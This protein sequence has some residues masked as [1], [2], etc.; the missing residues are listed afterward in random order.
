[1]SSGILEAVYVEERGR[2]LAT[3]IRMARNFEDA[4][5]ALQDAVTKWPRDS[6]PQNPGAWL[7]TVAKNSLIDRRR[8]DARRRELRAL[9]V[10]TQADEELP[11][12]VLRLIFLCCHPVLSPEAQIAL[13]LRT[14]GGLE[15][16]EIARA[17]L[18]P[19]PT[20][21]Q[22]LVRAKRKIAEAG[23]PYR[24]PTNQELPE[25]VDSVLG[26][27]YL[28]FNEGHVARA[29]DALLRVELCTE[30]IRLATLLNSWLP[31]RA[32]VEGLLALLILSHSRRDAR[33]KPD[34]SLVTLELQDRSLWKR[35]EIEQGTRLVETAL[36]RKSLGPYQV[37]AA[38]AALHSEAA[39]A[40]QTDWLQIASL[41][42]ELLRFDA[43]PVVRLNH[44]V[45]CG[46]AGSWQMAIGLI[47][48][49]VGLEEYYPYYAAKAQ[50]LQRLGR[51]A[52]SRVAL[53]RAIRLTQNRAEREYLS[54]MMRSS[55]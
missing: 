22:R 46:Y 54:R 2:I 47:Q 50:A 11:D 29:G 43:S 28:I 21:A 39:T 1:M 35:T 42:V 31:Q 45:A 6:V 13:T 41:Y 55:E 9:I 17:F 26:V 24:I 34:G 4:E 49:I 48:A 37:Q 23:V 36:R 51:Q 7:L 18:V 40:A 20:M 3:L 10:D 44:A 8:V 32:E 25:R 15:T 38:I 27:I 19:E 16:V 30:A 33:T 12:D 52:E 53:E 14:L 5:E